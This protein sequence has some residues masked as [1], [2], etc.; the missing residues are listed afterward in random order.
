[1]NG[2]KS[3]VS[4]AKT[5]EQNLK[6]KCTN[7]GTGHIM[8]AKS[9]NISSVQ[10]NAFIYGECT[11]LLKSYKRLLDADAEHIGGVGIKFSEADRRMASRG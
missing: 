9:T 2:I 10:E 4:I 11:A 1:M 8:E 6:T 7:L 3:N 5:Q